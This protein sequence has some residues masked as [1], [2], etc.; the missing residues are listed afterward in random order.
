M[1]RAVGGLFAFAVLAGQALLVAQGGSPETQ[2]K[3]AEQKAEIEGDYRAAIDVY[4]TV[5]AGSN[6]ALVAQA[7]LRMAEAY[8]KLGQAADAQQL[9]ERLI[10]DYPEQRQAI[11]ARRR[12][13]PANVARAPVTRLAWSGPETNVEGGVSFDGRS[14]CYSDADGDVAIRDLGGTG[15][16][17]TR[18]ATLRA[19]KRSG[20]TAER[21]LGSRE[22]LRRNTGEVTTPTPR[23]HI[24]ALCAEIALR[25]TSLASRMTVDWA[26]DPGNG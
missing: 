8:Q 21:N 23:R 4:K 15:R 17:V 19:L 5:A 3:A 12:L 26:D 22:C 1:I 6:R 14:L 7:M 11:E 20:W 25:L 24:V 9:H 18:T 2:L 13:Q 10:R 16:K